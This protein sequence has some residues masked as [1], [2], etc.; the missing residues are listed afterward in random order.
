MV[1]EG[2]GSSHEVGEG[3]WLLLNVEVF[4]LGGRECY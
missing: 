3:A 2:L 4:F 1:R